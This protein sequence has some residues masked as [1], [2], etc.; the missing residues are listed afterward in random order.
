MG[1]PRREREVFE[2]LRSRLSCTASDVRKALAQPPSY[3]TVRTI[4]ARLEKKGLV[5]RHCHSE[6]R[7]HLY[8]ALLSPAAVQETALRQVVSDLFDGSAVRAATLLLT[9]TDEV[10]NKELETLQLVIDEAKARCE[11]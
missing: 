8:L 9:L 10:E 3:S 4:L 1:L 11:A 5:K 6:S 2:T 7:A